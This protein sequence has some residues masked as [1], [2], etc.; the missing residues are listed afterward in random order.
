MENLF[1]IIENFAEI[2]DVELVTLKKS[3][4]VGLP[5]LK[6]KLDQ[7]IKLFEDIETDYLESRKVI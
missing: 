4:E 3:G 1:K 7:A 2:K 6:E 5:V